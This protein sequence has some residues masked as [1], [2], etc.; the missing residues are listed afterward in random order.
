MMFS[1]IKSS[2]D[3]LS[4]SGS[5]YASIKEV[6]QDISYYKGWD[7]KEQLHKAIKGWA[8]SAKPGSIFCTQASAIIAVAVTRCSREDDICH[9]CYH[10]GLDYGDLSPVEGGEIE[11]EV[12]CP[13]CRRRW[14]DI[15]ALVDQRE[16][17]RK[18]VRHE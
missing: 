10:D 1:V 12:T 2:L 14:K 11:Q 4:G 17:S 5:C 6:L 8:L 7:S 9:H 3:G 16:L 13:K 18:A 15:F